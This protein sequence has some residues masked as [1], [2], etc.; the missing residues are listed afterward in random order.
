VP[1]VF[2]ESDY[3]FAASLAKGETVS[4]PRAKSLG[5][6]PRLLVLIAI[7]QNEDRHS[8]K[9]AEMI[10]AGLPEEHKQSTAR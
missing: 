8:S 9:S 2:A 6:W 4:A 7:L 3:L 5:N 1:K 10:H